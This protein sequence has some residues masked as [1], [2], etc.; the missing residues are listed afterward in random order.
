MKNVAAIGCA[1]IAMVEAVEGIAELVEEVEGIADSEF[2]VQDQL[3]NREPEG[4]AVVEEVDSEGIA[5][6]EFAVLQDNREPEGVV[7]VAG[8]QYSWMI[9]MEAATP[10]REG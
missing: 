8:W 9:L 7:V 2:A 3:Q 6:S 10:A 1:E 5:D 4:V